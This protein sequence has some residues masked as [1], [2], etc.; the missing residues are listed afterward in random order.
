M[1]SQ[2]TGRSIDSIAYTKDSSKVV[3]TSHS[4]FGVLEIEN[5]PIRASTFD[6]SSF[7]Y[8]NL[9]N[10]SAG[11]FHDGTVVRSHYR[12]A[13]AEKYP[14]LS[15][16]LDVANMLIASDADIATVIGTKN[17]AINPY[18]VQIISGLEDVDV[19][20]FVDDFVLS[21]RGQH[22]AARRDLLRVW[23][24]ETGHLLWNEDEEYDQIA[25]FR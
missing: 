14:S 21:P 16:S 20:G 17:H 1:H 18:S 23:D 15:D 19:A 2:E 4:E 9:S 10:I 25:L 22:L 5:D 12:D 7:D 24:V 11:F 13:I 3:W 6:G 8:S